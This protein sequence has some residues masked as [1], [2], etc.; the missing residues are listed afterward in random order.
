M[1]ALAISEAERPLKEEQQN[2]NG[3]E[4]TVPKLEPPTKGWEGPSNNDKDDQ[5][6]ASVM[7]PAA[8]NFYVFMMINYGLWFQWLPTWQINVLG[9]GY[10]F[11]PHVQSRQFPYQLI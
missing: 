1:L 9:L 8:A 3:W 6:P 4:F 7:V 10:S 2:N 5:P 11:V